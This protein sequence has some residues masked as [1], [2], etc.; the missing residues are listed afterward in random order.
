MFFEK[1]EINSILKI[2]L[3]MVIATMFISAASASTEEVEDWGELES[4]LNNESVSEIILTDN[5]DAEHNIVFSSNDVVLNLSEYQL[6]VTGIIDLND[7]DN[8]NITGNNRDEASLLTQ[9]IVSN[10]ITMEG[11]AGFKLENI[12]LTLGESTSWF[13]VHEE[14]YEFRNLYVNATNLGGMAFNEVDFFAENITFIGY[15]DGENREGNN[16]THRADGFTILPWQ[17]NFNISGEIIFNQ[18]GDVIFGGDSNSTF[19]GNAIIDGS[20]NL[21][22]QSNVNVNESISLN[23]NSITREVNK[24]EGLI[25]ALDDSRINIVNVADGTYEGI[26]SVIHPQQIIANNTHDAILDGT[27]S[28]VVRISSND[29]TLN[30]FTIQNAEMGVAVMNDKLN[31]TIENNYVKNISSSNHDPGTG[32]SV[33]DNSTAS[34]FNNTLSNNDIGLLFLNSIFEENNIP[35]NNIFENNFIDYGVFNE[36]EEYVEIKFG[37]EHPFL[38]DVLL[39]IDFDNDPL[40]NST[41]V[42]VLEN[43]WVI[44]IPNVNITIPENTNITKLDGGNFPIFE[45]GTDAICFRDIDFKDSYGVMGAL[46]L[47][48]DEINLIFSKSVE[49]DINVGTEFEGEEIDIFKSHL[50]NDSE[51]WEQNETIFNKNCTIDGDGICTFNTIQA[52]YFV[53]ASE[54]VFN[55]DISSGNGGIIESPGEGVY[56]YK[57][58]TEVTIEADA[59]SGYEFD[60][61]TGD[62]D[63]IDD[64]ESA[65]TTITMDDNYEIKATFEKRDDDGNGGA[66]P[67]PESEEIEWED[68]EETLEVDVKVGDEIEFSVNG[69]DHTIELTALG[70][71]FATLEIN[72]NPIELTLYVGDT[73]EVDVTG[74]GNEDISVYLDRISGGYAYLEFERLEVEEEVI[75]DE[76]EEIEI[77]TTHEEVEEITEDHEEVEEKEEKGINWTLWITLISLISGVIAVTIFF[78]IKISE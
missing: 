17:N 1:F 73:E 12:N 51:S 14:G 78:K 21:T 59:D 10:G 7:F 22:I 16:Q 40:F 52:S 45:M 32:I 70:T 43:D 44:E 8:I 26:F 13:G 50:S 75:D 33:L 19:T 20:G 23:F 56:Y 30:G 37:I 67:A 18:D 42:K 77:T 34:F 55:L 76:D 72:S 15:Y 39:G 5:I 38:N 35:G 66:V 74:D 25:N 3:V 27:E 49:I 62:V 58:D 53:L 4:A 54:E 28:P 6:N 63:E 2:F 48:I 60:E 24:E 68:D 29:V 46:E 31:I 69:E 64:V 36:T 47:G 57:Y 65:E 61:W 9:G 11:S 41:S 71:T